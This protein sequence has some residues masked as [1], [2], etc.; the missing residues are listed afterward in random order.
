MGKKQEAQSLLK[1]AA[2]KPMHPSLEAKPTGHC[3]TLDSWLPQE[4]L[5]TA[6]EVPIGE[7]VVESRRLRK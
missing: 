4:N 1:I 6:L 5:S 7:Q 3:A 2:K